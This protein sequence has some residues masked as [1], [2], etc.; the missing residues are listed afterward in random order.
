MYVY[1]HKFKFEQEPVHVCCSLIFAVTRAGGCH[2]IA[3]EVFHVRP[4]WLLLFIAA[5]SF[6]PKLYVRPTSFRSPV[7]MFDGN[8]VVFFLLNNFNHLLFRGN[9]FYFWS[10][11]IMFQVNNFLFHS[12]MD[13][14][15]QLNNYFYQTNFMF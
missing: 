5:H 10:K 2:F 4:V 14:L 15:F 13:D 1:D 11:F 8:N 12:N 6:S 3:E 9:K 7:F